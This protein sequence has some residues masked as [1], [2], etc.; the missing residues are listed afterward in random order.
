M[1]TLVIGGIRSGKTE[2][3]E[4]LLKDKKN[5][6]Y[7]ATMFNFDDETNERII[8]HRK[9]RGDKFI[10]LES[11]KLEEDFSKVQNAILDDVG[12]LINNLIFEDKEADLSFENKYKIITSLKDKFDRLIQNF[13]SKEK[14]LVIV[15]NEVGL[16]LVS[17]YKIG[18]FFQDINGEINKFLADNS[19]EVY[20]ML[21]GQAVKIKW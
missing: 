7:I 15:T 8:N 16:T 1:I 11:L 5:K 20:F 12:N 17:E 10:T 14:K 6:H 9:N 2:F 3:S 4:N 18:R 21:V 19:D 13:K